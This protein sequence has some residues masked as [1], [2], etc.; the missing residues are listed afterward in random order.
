MAYQMAYQLIYKIK[1]IQAQY[2]SHHI[3]SLFQFA[4]CVTTQSTVMI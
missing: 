1:F 4:Q 3:Q 2:D